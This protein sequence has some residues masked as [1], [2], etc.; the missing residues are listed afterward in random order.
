MAKVELMYLDKPTGSV[1]P[2]GFADSAEQMMS[3]AFSPSMNPIPGLD[4]KVMNECNQ[5]G[6]VWYTRHEGN[7]VYHSTL[8]NLKSEIGYTK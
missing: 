8:E 5:N 1:F 6:K 2:C 7:V 3:I 4:E